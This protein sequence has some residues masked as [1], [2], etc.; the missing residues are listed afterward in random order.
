MIQAQGNRI[1]Q[2]IDDW[3]LDEEI[4]NAFDNQCSSSI[5]EQN[6]TPINGGWNL[7]SAP[8]ALNL[9]RKRSRTDSDY[10]YEG[11]G[12]DMKS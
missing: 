2:T 11:F 10:C 12:F 4:P 3:I 5:E 9:P 6:P 1:E 8:D 7:S